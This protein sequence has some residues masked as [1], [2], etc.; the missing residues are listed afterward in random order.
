[1]LKTITA[2]ILAT[3]GQSSIPVAP[4]GKPCSSWVTIGTATEK[5]EPVGY[6]EIYRIEPSAYP[7]GEHSKAD[8]L[9]CDLPICIQVVP[10]REN[11]SDCRAQDQ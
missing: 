7:P 2:A 4:A 1:M 5:V 6:T 10:M 8:Q 3:S 9:T 11:D